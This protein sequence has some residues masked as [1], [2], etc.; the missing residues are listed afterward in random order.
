MKAFLVRCE[1]EDGDSFEW[2]Q[3]LV[4]GRR[5]DVL[6]DRMIEYAESISLAE[7]RPQPV[8]I[9]VRPFDVQN[10]LTMQ[11]STEW[12]NGFFVAIAGTLDGDE[13]SLLDRA[14][15]LSGQH[16]IIVADAH[17]PLQPAWRS[18]IRLPV[19]RSWDAQWA[20]GIRVVLDVLLEAAVHRGLICIDPADIRTCIEGRCSQL[21]VAHAEGEDRTV[22]AVDK[23]V[24]A[25]SARVDLALAESFILTFHAGTDI[26][27]REIHQGL[28]KLKE[29]VDNDGK[30]IMAA[31]V[32]TDDNR[33]AVSLIASVPF[34]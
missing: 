12:V 29:T 25:L 6:A 19:H 32:P 16:C 20:W 7:C 28:E 10:W 18:V 15:A 1:Y 17:T 5:A 31:F 27:M 22:L 14:M 11:E 23:V 4:L 24:Q 3:F 2:P 34:D 8:A 13:C 30:V 9:K 26:L 33:F 21:A